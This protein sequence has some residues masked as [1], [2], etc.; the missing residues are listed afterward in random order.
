M[1]TNYSENIKKLEEYKK[2]LLE[3]EKSENTIEKYARDIRMFL[4]YLKEEYEDGEA[5]T[6]Q[7]LIKFKEKLE[8]SYAISSAN[9]ML[10]AVNVFLKYLG[11]EC[12]RV[13]LFK[14][15]KQV[16][17]EE[18]RELSKTDYMKLMEAAKLLHKNRLC[19]VMETICSTGIRISE[20]EY[21]TVGA[22]KIGRAEISCKGKKRIIFIPKKLCKKLIVYTRDNEIDTG[23]IFRTKTGRPLDRS[24]IWREM[25]KLCTD[26][27]VEATKV[28][29]HNFRHLFARTYYKIKKNIVHLADI[30]G[31][32]NINTTRIYTVSSGTEHMREIEELGLIV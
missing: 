11:L 23:I 14:V 29:P 1:N 17:S 2:W 19:L 25:K 26:A 5:V 18:S 21:I 32:S 7:H 13:K 28:F 24:N 20:L 12:L 3:D 27:C 6:K 30:L 8:G 10:V 31:H 9:S 15:Q 4:D 16:F 22:A